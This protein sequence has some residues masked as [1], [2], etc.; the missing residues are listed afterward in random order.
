MSEIEQLQ[1]ELQETR[2]AYQAAHQLQ[3]FKS[4]FLGRIAHELRSP[5]S[6][7]ISL[8]QL[9]VLDFCESREEERQFIEQAYQASQKLLAMLDQVVQVSKIDYGA[10]VLT[11]EV[12]NLSDILIELQTYIALPLANHHIP[13]EINLPA[14]IPSILVNESSLKQA[15]FSLLDGILLL[16]DKGPVQ[17]TVESQVSSVLMNFQIP[18]CREALENFS[19]LNLEEISL[20]NLQDFNQKLDYSAHLKLTFAELLIQ[21]LGGTFLQQNEPP[22]TLFQITLPIAE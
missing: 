16:L 7:L 11:P 15:L 14:V 4:S 19:S 13:L 5:L 9:I 22:Y 10:I 21:R 12:V 8:Q 6:S 18:D 20:E 1:Q 17:L 3:Q 2:L